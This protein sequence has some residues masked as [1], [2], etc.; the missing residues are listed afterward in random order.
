MAVKSTEANFFLQGKISKACHS[1]DIDSR[2]R[3]QL[4]CNSN[5]FHLF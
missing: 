5:F 2:G 4:A 1:D 3:P